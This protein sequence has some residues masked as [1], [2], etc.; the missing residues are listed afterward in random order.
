MSL[1]RFRFCFAANAQLISSVSLFLA[2]GKYTSSNDAAYIM[3][4][5]SVSYE[6]H[7]EK[8]W[9]LDMR[10]QRPK[11]NCAV[12]S[13]AVTAQ[14]ISFL[15][16]LHLEIQSIYFLNQ[17]P[18]SVVVQ[19]GFYRTSGPGWKPQRG[20]LMMRLIYMNMYIL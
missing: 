19:P 7:H 1:I 11:I 16:S 9:F 10:K 5:I 20:F 6:P 3:S 13:C 8:T 2:Y 18:S 14:L 12:T 4:L 15:F 17:K